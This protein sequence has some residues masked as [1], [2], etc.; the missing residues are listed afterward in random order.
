MVR[1]TK[2]LLLLFSLIAFHLAASAQE[3]DLKWVKDVGAKNTPT[4][5]KVYD[6][7]DYGAIADGRTLNTLAIQKA[8]DE[9][10][11]RGG[12]LV[13]FHPGTYLS[14][15]IFI[16]SGVNLNIPKG[17]TILGSTELKDYPELNSRIAGIEM[18]WPSALINVI[19]QNNAMLSGDGVI[20]GQGKVYWD[21]YWAMRKEY[22]TKG[23]RWIVDYDCKRPRTLVVSESS[24]ITVKGLTFQQAGFWTIQLL[25]SS[26]CT[27]DGVIIQNNIG[28]KGPS[29]DGVD[30]DSSSKI[31]VE[32]CDIDCN[33]DNFCLKA[34]RDADGLRVNR[35]TEYVVIRNCISRAGGG[36]LTC[37]SETSGGIRYVLAENLKAKGTLVGIRLKSALNRGGTTEQIY[38]RNIEMDQVGTVFEATM[39]WNPAYSYSVLPKE[40]EGKSLPEH[41]KKMLEK[42]DPS[43]GIPYFNNI[44]LSDLKITNSKEFLSVGGSEKSKMRHFNLKNIRVDAERIGSISYASDWKIENIDI[45]TK[46]LLPV[47]IS[48]STNV[49][50][51]VN[52]SY[53]D[54]SFPNKLQTETA[55]GQISAANHPEF[56]FQ[57]P[58]MAGN[59]KF[60]IIIGNRSKWLSE[61]SSKVVTPKGRQLT[62]V[63]TDSMLKGGKLTVMAISLRHTDGLIAQISGE[64]IPENA[65][66]FWSYG[67]AVGSTLPQFES[68][69]LKPT[70]CRDNV[71]SVEHNAFTLY[72]GES[73]KLKTIIGVTPPTSLIRLSDSNIQENPLAFFESGK[74]TDAPALTASLPLKSGKN[75]YFCLYKQNSTADYNYFMLPKLFQKESNN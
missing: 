71:F 18:R 28:G 12:G 69:S 53:S 49:I 29:T 73:M 25:Y 55:G 22:E 6:V 34:G 3:S 50:F 67:G 42:V 46:N 26:N 38:V 16:K 57:L 11:A 35:P 32:N 21:S 36:L 5:T 45:R 59:L 65:Q 33:D 61:F 14:G 68:G 17:V 37:G 13:T 48:N 30:I 63:L 7:S 43:K 56:A 62:Y 75:E 1:S 54:I 60:G 47:S 66:L 20:N 27:I 31:L 10:S 41:W 15:S 64:K 24:D 39:N 52:K 72:Y 44:Y 51:P 8:I 70:Y 74:K 4:S 40:F 19:G 58:E 23:L 2:A 9:C